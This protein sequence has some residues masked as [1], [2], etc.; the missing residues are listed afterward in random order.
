[1]TVTPSFEQRGS[2]GADDIESKLLGVE[3]TLAIEAGAPPEDVAR[4][5]RT[6]ERMC[7]LMDAIR[8]PHSLEQRTLLNGNALF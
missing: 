8:Q 3:T 5:V 1:M 6:A 7:F 2:I 4:L